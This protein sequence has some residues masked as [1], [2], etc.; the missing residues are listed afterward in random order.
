MSLSRIAPG[1]PTTED[2]GNEGMRVV[3]ILVGN[4]AEAQFIQFR[5]ASAAGN[6]HRPQDRPSDTAA[7]E[8][9]GRGNLQ[10][11]EEKVAIKGLMIQD[12][13]IWN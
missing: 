13:C 2:P 6:V 7:N 4:I 5:L 10:V 9:Y 1:V 11:S 8:A 3:A 12:I